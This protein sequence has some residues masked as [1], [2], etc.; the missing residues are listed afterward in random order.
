MI[1]W[2][3]Q[4]CAHFR[5]GY[6]P[7]QK[8]WTSNHV[9]QWGGKQGT[10]VN[11]AV[12]HITRSTSYLDVSNYTSVLTNVGIRWHNFIRANI[13]LPNAKRTAASI[14]YTKHIIHQKTR[15]QSYRI[16]KV[17]TSDTQKVI[18]FITEGHFNKTIVC[19]EKPKPHNCT[20]MGARYHVNQPEC[21]WRPF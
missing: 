17:M 12:Q 5:W 14:K 16:A 21:T 11:K 18:A 2:P 10:S 15:K 3:F 1:L 20:I 9:I 19:S 4:D 13:E 8:Y 7:F 6:M